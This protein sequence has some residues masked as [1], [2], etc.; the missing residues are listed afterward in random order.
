MHCSGMGDSMIEIAKIAIF[1]IT[2]VI[3][4]M[5]F[6]SSKPEYAFYVGTGAAL[7]LFCYAIRFVSTVADRFQI[8]QEYFTGQ[9]TYL[10]TLFKII[11]I[12]YICE[13]GSGLCK[14]AG[15]TSVAGQIEILGKLSV[16]FA[17]LPI[18]FAVMDEIQTFV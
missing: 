17:G 18:L 14:D 1:G 11:G 7:L 8:L 12:T 16:I 4:A 13:F 15:Y 2:G 9:H 10:N 5:Q 3:L 6:K